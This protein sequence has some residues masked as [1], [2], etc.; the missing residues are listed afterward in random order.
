M[1]NTHQ[2]YYEARIK[3]IYFSKMILVDTGKFQYT[4]GI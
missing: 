3:H 1:I 2:K 4:S